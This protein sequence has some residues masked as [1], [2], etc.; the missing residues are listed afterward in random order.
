MAK[1]KIKE[2]VDSNPKR[3]HSE[4][5]HTLYVK[6]VPTKISREKVKLNLY[7]LF[8]TYADVFQILCFKPGQAWI[9]VS[10]IQEAN[11]CIENLNDFP[12]F[13]KR[14]SVQFAKCDS[15]QMQSLLLK[16]K[17]EQEEKK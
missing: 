6:N 3:A 2:T 5:C 4:A 16:Y 11:Q 17:E 13:D 10:S 1:R 12:F 15:K 7:V 8:A 9:S 14:L